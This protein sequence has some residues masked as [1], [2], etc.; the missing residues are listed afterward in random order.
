MTN[1]IQVVSI[2]KEK[3]DQRFRHESHVSALANCP[4]LKTGTFEEYNRLYN[5]LI[6][7][8]AGLH[9]TGQYE[10]GPILTSLA[11]PSG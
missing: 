5:L 10:V 2:L 4:P 9:N 11:P 3:Y 7:H 6:K 8:D 1:Y